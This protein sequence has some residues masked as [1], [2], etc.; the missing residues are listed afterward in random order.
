MLAVEISEL[1]EHDPLTP[2][3][4][5]ILEASMRHCY[6]GLLPPERVEVI[7]EL[8]RRELHSPRPPGERWLAAL[9]GEHVR[10]VA[11][12]RLDA[13]PPELIRCYVDPD[14]RR[15]GVGTALLTAC[16][17]HLAEAQALAGATLPRAVLWVLATNVAAQHFYRERGWQRAGE[18]RWITDEDW[19]LDL[20]Y[21][22]SLGPPLAGG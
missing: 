13:D 16:E 14:H 15:R 2:L 12:L 1:T 18:E 8:A 17:A 4:A 3:A 5:D 21:V 10:G 19:A 20:C 22:R 9:E 11:H 6:E 7:T